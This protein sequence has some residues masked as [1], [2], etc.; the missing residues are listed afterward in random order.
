M[1]GR[2]RGIKENRAS[3]PVFFPSICFK[4]GYV[5][6]PAQETFKHD[7]IYTFKHDCIYSHA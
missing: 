5:F 3:T 7:C 1:K 4:T 6:N 2:K